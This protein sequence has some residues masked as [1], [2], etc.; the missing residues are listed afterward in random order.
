MAYLGQVELIVVLFMVLALVIV[1]GRHNHIHGHHTQDEHVEHRRAHQVLR[2]QTESPVSVIRNRTV[3]PCTTLN[4]SSFCSK[5]LG[6][7]VCFCPSCS[8]GNTNCRD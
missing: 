5:I 7:S 6:L 2:R 3:A 8:L 1:A 4:T